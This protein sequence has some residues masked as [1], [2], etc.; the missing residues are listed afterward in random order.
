MGPKRSCS[1]SSFHSCNEHITDFQQ[2]VPWPVFGMLTGR[3]HVS[4]WGNGAEGSFGREDS[5]EELDEG[6]DT[7]LP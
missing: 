3:A 7:F 1:F 2:G 6:T 5:Y 4:R